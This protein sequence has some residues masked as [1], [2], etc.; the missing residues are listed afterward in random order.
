MKENKI[1][2]PYENI[3]KSFE[4]TKL[5]APEEAIESLDALISEYKTKAA[6]YEASKN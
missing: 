4:E 6:E 3:I 1:M 5:T 2:N